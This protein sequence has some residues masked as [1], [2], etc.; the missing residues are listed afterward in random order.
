MKICLECGS[1][2]SP[3]PMHKEETGICDDCFGLGS[4]NPVDHC[5]P[6]I[7]GKHMI[8]EK[9]PEQIGVENRRKQRGFVIR[10][11]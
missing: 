6:K 5:R 1:M 2:I 10:S 4:T 11:H 8:I 7:K 9:S 3:Y